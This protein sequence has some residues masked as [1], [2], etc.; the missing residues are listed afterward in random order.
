M[1]IQKLCNVQLAAWKIYITYR[2]WAKIA[3]LII[4]G[5]VNYNVRYTTLHS[6]KNFH[7]NQWSCFTVHKL[8][9]I[10]I[11]FVLCWLWWKD[12]WARR[13]RTEQKL[14][15]FEQ[16]W[17]NLN[18]IGH[19]VHTLNWLKSS[20]KGTDIHFGGCKNIHADSYTYICDIHLF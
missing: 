5:A 9:L 16:I 10:D 8:S 19:C 11:V 20:I 12:L 3:A 6:C 18:Q 17:T 4:T 1:S 15:R 14:C 7:Y 2:K 13:T